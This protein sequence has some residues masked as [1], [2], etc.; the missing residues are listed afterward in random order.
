MWPTRI[1]LP[2]AALLAGLLALAPGG[3]RCARA[4]DGREAVSDAA[5][6]L[7]KELVDMLR[8]G[9][10]GEAADRLDDA[11]RAT[12]A[13]SPGVAWSVTVTFAERA[14]DVV[15]SDGDVANRLVAVVPALVGAD[16]T[17]PPAS[18]VR[19]VGQLLASVHGRLQAAPVP[20]GRT[21]AAVAKLV[22][23][24]KKLASVPSVVEGAYRLARH[25]A[26][27]RGEEADAWGAMLDVAGALRSLRKPG[28][29]DE[30]FA[31]DIGVGELSHGLLLAARGGEDAAAR[32]LLDRGIDTLAARGFGAKRVAGRWTDE[33]ALFN[34]AMTR[35]KALGSTTKRTWI[36]DDHKFWADRLTTKVPAFA[37]W[38]AS[39]TDS[40]QD[41]GLLVRKRATDT[42]EIQ[43]WGYNGWTEYAMGDGSTVPGENVDGFLKKDMRL[44]HELLVKVRSESRAAGALSPTIRAQKG[45]EIE[46]IDAGGTPVRHRNWYFRHSLAVRRYFNVSVTQSG[47]YDEK[48]PELLFVLNGLREGGEGEK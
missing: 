9:L 38:S 25:V 35:A 8:S 24:D 48:D 28:P 33:T 10:F 30:A 39:R 37:G 34:R 13:A 23:L 3:V 2:F 19:A 32:T 43:V 42:I 44:D 11:A 22:T 14:V 40:E 45:Y 26:S 46:G 47:T 16:D 18:G 4:D 17:G 21:K 29:E 27:L 31:R 41:Y 7:G 12:L 15:R 20:L 5:S 1:R 36:T 6:A